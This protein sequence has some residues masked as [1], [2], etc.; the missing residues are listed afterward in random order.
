MNELPPSTPSRRKHLTRDHRIRIF[1]L[2]D[3][4]FNQVDIARGLNITRRQVGY[5]LNKKDSPTPSKRSGRPSSL[6]EDQ[7]DELEAFVVSSRAGRE[8]SYFELARIQFI[9]WNVSE[10]VV[11]RVL[12]LRGYERRIAQPKPPLTPDH[13]RRRKRWA[14]EHLSW[15]V[16]DWS[17]ILWTDETWVT[18]QCHSKIWVTRK[19]STDKS[20]K[21]AL[22]YD[23]SAVRLFTL[24]VSL[25]KPG[26]SLV[27]CSGDHSLE[28]KKGRHY[29]GRKAGA[30]LRRKN[31]ARKYYLSSLISFCQI[32]PYFL[33]R[34]VLPATLLDAQGRKCLDLEYSQSCG[35]HFPLI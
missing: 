15:T 35:L 33:C 4:S 20:R 28:Q 26:A 11:R 23:P 13:M 10:D 9:D 8:M 12:R 24:I 14:E 31:T 21:I 22:T 3:H 32:I 25:Q 19:V 29:F 34:M 2:H 27:G 1:A 18:G 16:E 17:K 6:S 7:V 5:A 30:L